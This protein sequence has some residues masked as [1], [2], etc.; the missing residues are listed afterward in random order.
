MA[1]ALLRHM[2][3]KE[4]LNGI[5]LFSRGLSVWPNEPMSRGAQETLKAAGIHPG[6]HASHALEAKDVKRADLILAMTET[7]EQSILAEYPEAKGKTRRLASFDIADP[8]GGSPKDY[9]KCRIDIQNAL[10]DLFIQLKK[11]E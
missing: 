1:A 10:L 2:L 9:E 4:R 3:K 7:H 6:P 8:V 11:D 5:E